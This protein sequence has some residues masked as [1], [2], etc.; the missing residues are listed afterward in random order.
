MYFRPVETLHEGDKQQRGEENK[1][2]KHAATNA[3]QTFAD[4]E[5][6]GGLSSTIPNILEGEGQKNQR[7]GQSFFM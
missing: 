1:N 5:T 6:N 7:E 4:K 3:D 2:D